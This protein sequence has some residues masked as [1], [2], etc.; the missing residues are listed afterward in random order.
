MS[1]QMQVWAH[2]YAMNTAKSGTCY[3]SIDELVICAWQYAEAMQKQVDKRRAKD[4][5]EC[6]SDE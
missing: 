3:G 1:E 2:E 4:P 5:F 6:K